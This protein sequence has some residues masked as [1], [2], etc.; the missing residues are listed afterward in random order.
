MKFTYF[1]KSIEF[2]LL[3]IYVIKLLK[4]IL[5][6]CVSVTSIKPFEPALCTKRETCQ[7]RQA[8]LIKQRH[9]PSIQAPPPLSSAEPHSSC[10]SHRDV[11]VQRAEPFSGRKHGH[12]SFRLQ[13]TFPRWQF[14]SPVSVLFWLLVQLANE[15]RGFGS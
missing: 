6:N 12:A 2:C 8:I 10:Y 9:S 1:I 3:H 11:W 5:Y 7:V 4:F 13:A 14:T 15:D